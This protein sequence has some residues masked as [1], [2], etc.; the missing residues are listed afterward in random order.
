MRDPNR[1]D[2]I[3]NELKELWHKCPDMRF[4]QLISAVM[5]NDDDYKIYS[6]EGM[7][8]YTFD[9]FYKED[10]ET[11]YKIMTFQDTTE[12]KIKKLK[13]FI[14]MFNETLFSLEEKKKAGT[15]DDYDRRHSIAIK[16]QLKVWNIKLGLL[17][18][19]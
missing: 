14:E 10:E 1:I 4:H 18:G 5:H 7:P 11:E 3:C 12:N 13:S 15:Y 19:K 8:S 2:R 16:K 17:N 6:L 9:Y